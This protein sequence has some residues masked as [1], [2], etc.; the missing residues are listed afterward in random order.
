MKK[1]LI[2]SI[3]LV[4][5]VLSTAVVIA[6]QTEQEKVTNAYNWLIGKVKNNW[7]LL[8]TKENEFSLL[9]LQCN[10]TY[11]LQGNNSL[12]Q[13]AYQNN[14]FACFG[15][16]ST[17]SEDQ[18]RLTETSIAKIALDA[19]EE[20][21]TKIEDWIMSRNKTYVDSSV[22]W[23]LQIDVNRDSN[24]SC[25]IYY[26]GKN[27]TGFIINEDKS[28]TLT[29][30]HECFQQ[31]PNYQYWFHMK[32]T[33]PCLSADYSI[34]CWSDNA[35]YVLA[36]ILY[37]RSTSNQWY[38]SSETSTGYPARPGEQPLE[39]SPILRV[40][41]YCLAEKNT[42]QC[43]YEGTAWGTYALILQGE[44]EK[45]N[46]FIPYLVMNEKDNPGYFPS[47]FL[48]NFLNGVYVTKAISLKNTM[49][50][51]LIQPVEYGTL[52][53][54]ALAKIM[55]QDATDFSDS[56]SWILGLQ[57]TAGYFS[58]TIHP[59]E[60]L[61]RDNAFVLWAFW[62]EDCPNGG[63]TGNESECAQNGGICKDECAFDDINSTFNCPNNQVCCIPPGGGVESCTALGG[64]CR[65]S[66]CSTGETFW[67]QGYCSGSKLCCVAYSD[68]T[69][70]QLQGEFCNST[71]TCSGNEIE[72]WD[73]FGSDL[74]C[75]GSC[76]AQNT[77]TM[78][79]S[80]LFGETCTSSQ[81]CINNARIKIGLTETMD[82]LSCCV[83]GTCV[84]NEYCS[85]IGEDCG[86]AD[87]EGST[88]KTIDVDDCCTGTCTETSQTCAQL[89]GD[90][91]TS[92]Q[93][94]SGTF[95]TASDGRCCMNGTCEGQKKGGFPI[96]IIVII[97][98]VVL[99]ALYFFV[100]KKKKKEEGEEDIFGL[101]PK[102]TPSKPMTMMP[103]QRPM[104][105][106]RPMRP[107]PLRQI[108]QRQ[109]PNFPTRLEQRPIQKLPTKIPVSKVNKSGKQTDLEK[110][111]AKL[112]KL[113]K[114]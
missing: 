67:Q 68:M 106:M 42:N 92:G 2:I 70:S 112:K 90:L 86:T 80:Q 114:K 7:S 34:K 87:C 103:I 5:L 75:L 59:K 53:N 84:E 82:T 109:F 3:L 49:G 13:R 18:C 88:V 27:E 96:L 43:N 54:T 98:I 76:I 94:C 99:A 10:T 97:I 44:K 105:P 19:I 91:C 95:R 60:A 30:T 20:N 9:A 33:E 110:T 101:K 72:T 56:K 108:P 61:L 107:M 8:N 73:S 100:I 55:L 32:E 38:V 85:D 41:S 47:A 104:S 4:F 81:T 36:N 23:F 62:P 48:A 46:L 45:A 69:C 74:C 22:Q 37:K 89:G 71:S 63:S 12:W 21:T 113:T 111:L 57:K 1:E 35:T 79:C 51:W 11:K 16:N 14:K 52:Y 6:E 93:T 40:P 26:H 64:S 31:L 29:G 58:D 66:N 24:A 28:V 15:I 25:E 102:T 65:D 50:Y 78:T 83:G 77:S 17:G 39:L